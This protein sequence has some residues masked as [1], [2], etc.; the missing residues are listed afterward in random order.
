VFRILFFHLA[1]AGIEHEGNLNLLFL[2][3]FL[4]QIDIFVFFSSSQQ[5]AVLKLIFSF[6]FHLVGQLAD[7]FVVGLT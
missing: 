7:K 2:S 3:A 1:R 4:I 6:A 5:F